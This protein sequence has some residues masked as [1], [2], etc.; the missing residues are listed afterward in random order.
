[1]KL[2]NADPI[3]SEDDAASRPKRAYHQGA[4]ARAAEATAER[5]LDA[6]Q[7]RISDDWFDQITLEQIARDAEV[8][9]PTVVRRFGSKDG[10]LDAVQQRLA[11]EIKTRRKIAPGDVA[12]AI[13]VLVEDY[14]A[15]G[16]LVMRALSQE[17]RHP[18]FK[19][20]ADIGR[21]YHRAW[22]DHVFTPWLDPLLPA[23]R[24]ARLDALVI[25]TDL[26]VW[27]LARRDMGRSRDETHSL[28]RTLVAGIIGSAGGAV[29]PQES[30]RD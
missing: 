21:A 9:V 14:D 11:G 13:A 7:R 2:A 17:E 8:T 15:T 5:I 1:M 27:K 22:I 28:I 18:P 12:G 30:H 29:R 10:L 24:Q 3:A 6:F 25:A 23:A 4:R 19:V 20:M 16:D 26:Y